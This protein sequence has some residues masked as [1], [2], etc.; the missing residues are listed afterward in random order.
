[1]ISRRTFL[2]LG[3]GAMAGAALMGAPFGLRHAAAAK[4]MTGVYYVPPSYPA[5]TWGTSGFVDFMKK[6]GDA[7]DLN[8]YGSGELIKADQQLPALRARNID[9]MFHTTSYITRSVPILGITGLPGVVDELYEHGDRIKIGTPL[10]DLINEE[11]AKQDL[12]QLTAGGGVLE[13]EYIW[14]TKK[15]PIRSLEDLRGKKV[16]VVSY[17]ATE[18]LKPYGAAAVRIPSSDTYMAL[19]RGTIDAAV[20]NIS[21]VIG[22]SLHEQLDY[23]YKLPTTAF[24]VSL[25]M[26]RSTWDNL[27]PEVRDDFEAAAKWYDDNFVEHCNTKAYPTFHWEKVREAGIE[28]FEPS[29]ED[30]ASYNKASED[31]RKLW[32]RDVGEAVGERAIALALGEA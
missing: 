15:R 27:S 20:L 17:E 12:Y 5:L 10:F 28:A 9:F 14:S 16:R 11:L 4:K 24:T 19:Q 22:R 32:T 18:A 30:I 3:T 23:V 6:Y 2:Q 21:T 26:L 8:F 1:M 7:V 29:Q 31:V 25:F 13:P